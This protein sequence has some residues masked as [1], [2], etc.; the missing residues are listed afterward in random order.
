MDSTFKV[1]VSLNEIPVFVILSAYKMKMRIARY[2]RTYNSGPIS[3]ACFAR[4]RALFDLKQI[5]EINVVRV[6]VIFKGFQSICVSSAEIMDR[7]EM[8]CLRKCKHLSA[9]RSLL[10][11]VAKAAPYVVAI[12]SLA[13]VEFERDSIA[14]VLVQALI[15]S[16]VVTKINFAITLEPPS[17]ILRTAEMK[18]SITICICTTDSSTD[19]PAHAT[20]NLFPPIDCFDDILPFS[21]FQ[22]QPL[23]D[24]TFPNQHP[25]YNQRHNPFYL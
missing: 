23:L 6:G 12:G 24:L 13:F 22:Q 8:C 10:T 25:F 7:H 16:V 19:H 3:A 17:C 15:I 5:P 2:V 14:G 18:T 11:F 1:T 4:L 9:T 20:G 21:I